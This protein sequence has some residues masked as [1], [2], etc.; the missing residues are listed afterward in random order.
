[1]IGT[2]EYCNCTTNY[3]GELTTMIHESNK[4]GDQIRSISEVDVV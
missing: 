4:L 2:G 3:S 1:M